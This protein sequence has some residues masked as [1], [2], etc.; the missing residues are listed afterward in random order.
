M[1]RGLFGR[2]SNLQFLDLSWFRI[3][4]SDQNL[5]GNA[6]YGVMASLAH[7]EQCKVIQNS[8]GFWI[9]RC[10]IF[11]IQ[12]LDCRFYPCRLQKGISA[13]G[14]RIHSLA[15]FWIPMPSV[16]DSTKKISRIP[17]S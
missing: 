13:K 15:G 14:F 7:F 9:P 8:I 12:V 6:I 16:P 1:C 5:F 4:N 3:I 2:G 17:E 10:G 11:G